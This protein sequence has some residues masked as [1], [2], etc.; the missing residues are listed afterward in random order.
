[1]HGH[2]I[3]KPL[4]TGPRFTINISTMSIIDA[5]KALKSINQQIFLWMAP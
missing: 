2:S 4:P 3:N 1:M 5:C